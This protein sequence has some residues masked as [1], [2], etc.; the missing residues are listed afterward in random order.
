MNRARF[1]RILAAIPLTWRAHAASSAPSPPAAP[2]Q[3]RPIPASGEA[4]PVIGCGT[5]IGFDVALD[6]A[7]RPR[8]AAVLAALREAGGTVIDSSPMYGRAEAGVGTLVEAAAAR[9]GVFLATKVWTDGRDAGIRQME[10]SFARLRTTTIDLMQVHN[11]VDWRTHLATLRR[12]QAE[13][14]VRYVGVTHYTSGAYPELAAVMRAEKLDFVQVNYA[15]DER[16]AEARILPL[17]AERGMAVLVNR[18]L[19]GGGLLRRLAT[20][21]LPA[22]AA[23]IGAASWAEV[24]LKF[25]LSHPAVTCAIPGTGDPGHMATNARAGMGTPVDPAFWRTHAAELRALP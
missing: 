1:L 18:P 21:P 25:V 9:R 2:L 4:L 24:L 12:W 16:E 13:G 23:D 15:L 5:Y 8:L 22:W 19:G 11:L 20:R 6:A 14:R 3:T 7:S 10:A 17:A